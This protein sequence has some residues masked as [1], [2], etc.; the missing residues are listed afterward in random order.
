MSTS[1][2]RCRRRPAS[3]LSLCR[4]VGVSGF[5]TITCLPASSADRT[6]SKCVAAG[7]AMATAV[8]P[9]PPGSHR[10]RWW[11]ALPYTGRGRT[12][13]VRS[14]DHR[15]NQAG[16]RAWPVPYGRDSVPSS[17]HRSLPV[18]SACEIPPVSGPPDV[19][20]S[21]GWTS[22]TQVTL[23][24]DVR[25]S[26]LEHRMSRVSHGLMAGRGPQGRMAGLQPDR[27]VQAGHFKHWCQSR[28]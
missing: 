8:T 28:R 14:G 12:W 15:A 5:S 13:P 4:R 26:D 24:V 21:P 10:T 27:T 16:T 7:V 25:E 2:G 17:Q 22:R 23:Y 3:L 18:P 9:G 1:P 20:T 19:G 11:A 6:R